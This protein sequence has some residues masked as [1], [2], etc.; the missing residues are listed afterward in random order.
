MKK[1]LSVLLCVAAVISVMAIVATQAQAT[2]A[3]VIGQAEKPSQT[4]ATTAP[5]TTERPWYEGLDEWW[6]N[7][8]PIFDTVWKGGLL[9]VSRLLTLGF[10]FILNLAGLGLWPGGLPGIF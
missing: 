6:Q 7:F 4:T 9:W 8:Y 3:N 2:S 10:Q 5:P 1:I